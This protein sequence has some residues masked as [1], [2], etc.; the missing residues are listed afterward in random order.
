MKTKPDLSR[1]DHPDL[2][3]DVV[4]PLDPGGLLLFDG[5]VHHGT[6]ANRSNL[7]RRALQYHYIPRGTRRTSQEERMSVFGS[8][9][10]DV[11]C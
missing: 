1:D 5:L 3:R 8:E 6:P 11:E 9:G 4:V 10:K 2:S 7:Q